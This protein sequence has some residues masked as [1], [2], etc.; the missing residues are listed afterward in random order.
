MLAY[1]ICR[2]PG[3]GSDRGLVN[4]IRYFSTNE[5]NLAPYSKC[6]RFC[7]DTVRETIGNDTGPLANRYV[8][9]NP[10]KEHHWILSP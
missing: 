6:G 2:R 10:G 7:L 9:R 8:S 3:G 4:N 5:G 1:I